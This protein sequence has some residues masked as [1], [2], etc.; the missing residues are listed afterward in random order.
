MVTPELTAAAPELT[1]ANRPV[2]PAQV[3]GVV[4]VGGGRGLGLVVGGAGE[5]RAGG[6]TKQNRIGSQLAAAAAVPRADR[7]GGLRAQR[8]FATVPPLF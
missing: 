2:G 5:L 6:L 3:V 1:E 7:Q 4:V 8:A